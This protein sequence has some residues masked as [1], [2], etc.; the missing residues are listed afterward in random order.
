[1][2]I[3]LNNPTVKKVCGIVS[4]VVVGAIATVNA[5]A[6]QKKAQEFEDMKKVLSELQNK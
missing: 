3:N 1:M 4:A 6:D 5:L 2:K